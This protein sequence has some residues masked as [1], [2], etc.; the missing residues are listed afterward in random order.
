[1]SLSSDDLTDM[2][3]G[4]ELHGHHRTSLNMIRST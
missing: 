1:L 2:C 3:G 4:L